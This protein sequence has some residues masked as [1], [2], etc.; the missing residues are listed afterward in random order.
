MVSLQKVFATKLDT[1]AVSSP[2]SRTDST[3]THL[4]SDEKSPLSSLENSPRASRNAKKAFTFQESSSNKRSLR[5]AKSSVA[6]SSKINSNKLPELLEKYKEVSSQ[7]RDEEF[8]QQ[9]CSFIAKIAG[10]ESIPDDIKGKFSLYYILVSIA[11]IFMLNEYEIALLACTL[12]KCE[13]NLDEIVRED[14]G[15]FLTEFPCSLEVEI[16]KES[17]QLIIYILILTFALKGSLSEKQEMELIQAYCEKIC[18][19]FQD[20][21][22]RSSKARSN[23][24]LNFSHYE[25]NKKFRELSKRDNREPFMKGIKDYNMVVES[26][27]RLTGSHTTKPKAKIQTQRS[28]CEQKSKCFE[29]SPLEESIPDTDIFYADFNKDFDNFKNNNVMDFTQQ[30]SALNEEDV[31]NTKREA[32]QEFFEEEMEL[33]SKKVKGNNDDVF[34]FFQSQNQQSLVRKDFMD[35]GKQY[36]PEDFLEVVDLSRKTSN[37]FQFQEDVPLFSRIDSNFSLFGTK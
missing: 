20:L 9:A 10:D 24:K 6:P 28:K 7:Y 12:D 33:I 21:L 17:R 8:S 22:K 32:D 1:H 26:I 15:V 4:T 5:S 27:L 35:C 34:G 25:V 11:K 36:E 14:E 13:W 29:E 31:I 3:M 23:Y 18:K 2:I 30:L 19:N 37:F 16:T